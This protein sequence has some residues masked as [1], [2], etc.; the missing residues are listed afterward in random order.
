MTYEFLELDETHNR[1]LLQ[2]AKTT[3]TGSDLF[4]VDRSPNFFSLSEEFGMTRHFGLF[5][6]SE[7]IGCVAVSEQKRVLTNRCENVYY[8]NDLRIHPD[9]HRTFAFYRLAENI[10]SLYRNEG[11]VKWMIS[12]VLDS[13]TNKTSMTK[14]NS[15]LPGGVEIGRTIHIGIPMFMK[16]RKSQ[17][18]ICEINGEEAWAI[19][20]KLARLQPFA[21][22]EKRMFLSGNGVFLRIRDKNKDELAICKLVDQSDARKLRLSR[23]LPFSFKIVNLFCRFADCPPLPNHGEEFRHGYMAYFTAK[24]KPQNYQKEFISFIQ[25]EF[26]HKYSYLFLGVSTEEAQY[27]RSNPFYIKLSSTTFAYGDVP[28]NLSMDFHELTLI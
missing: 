5:K 23:K 11:N 3:N 24:E 15:L 7:L 9:Y 26:K 22:C 28:P 17:L 19:Y 1:Q 16:Y 21:P 25:K 12:T 10:L 8:L 18:D 2:L 13:N 4:Y 6:E 14:G 20:K 27:F